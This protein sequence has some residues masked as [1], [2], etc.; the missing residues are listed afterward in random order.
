[1]TRPSAPLAAWLGCALAA[2]VFY[3]L[4][5]ALADNPFYLQWQRRDLLE[6]AVAWLVLAIAGIAGVWVTWA[7]PTRAG[8]AG[9]MAITTLP[10]MS[11]LAG[12]LQQLPFDTQLVAA[13]DNPALRYG[14]PLLILTLLVLGIVRWPERFGLWLRR[15]LVVL[16]LVALVVAQAFVRSAFY[17]QVPV[18]IDDARQ[19][20]AGCTSVVALLFDELSFPYVYDAG[21]VR[22]ELPALSRVAATATSYLRV[23]APARDTLMSLPGYLAGRSF[24]DVRVDRGRL[25][26]IDGDESAE[27]FSARDADSLF[28]TAR[29]VGLRTEIAGYYLPYC[30]LLSGVADRCQSL[31]FYNAAGVDTAFSPLHPIATTL[32]LWPR[33]FPFGLAKNPAFARLQRD[34]V[35]RTAQFAKQPVA[36]ASFRFVHFSVPHLPFVFTDSGFDP[37][38][39]PLRTSPDDAY[40]RQVRYAD[41]LLGDVVDRMQRDGSFDSTTLVVLSDHGYRF[42]GRD[43]DPL[44]IPF[45]VKAAGQHAARI[46][47]SARPAAELLRSLV[48]QACPAGND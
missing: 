20:T 48:T 44:H 39:D 9:L 36:R 10:V 18:A 27:V 33:Q 7:R 42:G 28:A 8:N 37:P 16:S 23:T 5:A 12:V 38:F 47:T 26:K 24:H 6:V 30:D 14:I 22:G 31:S 13:W 40:A 2:L 21:T 35:E 32:I 11:L 41:R 25:V 1:V 46:D 45:I 17:R 3:P 29:R 4:A 34:L 15:T 19:G 43:R